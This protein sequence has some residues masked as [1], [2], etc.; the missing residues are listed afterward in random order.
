MRYSYLF[1]VFFCFGLV[2]DEVNVIPRPN[3]LRLKKGHFFQFSG[4]LKVK[5]TKEVQSLSTLLKLDHR[6]VSKSADLNVVL[7][8]KA[9][10][11]KGSYRLRVSRSG[12]Y[13][14]SRNRA[15]LVN[16]IATL[17]Q[18]LLQ[19]RKGTAY[20]VPMLQIR[21]VPSYAYRGLM[22]DSARHFQS[23]KGIKRLLDQMALF[24]L[25]VFHWHLTD[26]EGWRAEVTEFPNL[27]KIGG[28]LDPQELED[29]RNGYYTEK[30]LREVARYANFRGIEVIPEID[31]P[32]HS[33]A[34]VEACPELACPTHKVA[35]PSEWISNQGPERPL[36]G[37]DRS[38]I[39]CVGNDKL[40][41]FLVT[42]YKSVAKSTGA[43]RVHIGGDEVQKG[44]WSKCPKCTGLMKKQGLKDEYDLER[45]FLNQVS[46]RLRQEG[47]EVINWCESPEKGLPNVNATLVWRGKYGS[48]RSHIYDSV[49]QGKKVILARDD[50]A[51]YNYP[52][53]LGTA[54]PRWMPS[55]S[56]E[57]VYKFPLVEE[58]LNAE[59]KSLIIGGQCSLWTEN[60]L[61]K[62]IDEMLFPRVL[63]FSERLWTKSTRQDYASFSSRF[64]RLKPTL[65]DLG[66]SFSKPVL[67]GEVIA[68]KG[69]EVRSNME[70]LLANYAEYAF[71]Q[72]DT[73][74]FVSAKPAQA[75]DFVM[76]L[77]PK[78]VL[79]KEIVVQTGGFF[80]FDEQKGQA[81]YAILEASRDGDTWESLSEL[82]DAYTKVNVKRSYKAIRLRITKSQ[83]RRLVLPEFKIV[84]RK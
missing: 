41:D 39:L 78:A 47:L 21:D 42:I 55:L 30:E 27:T 35:Y 61:E 65:S 59:E 24:K 14:S 48:S 72:D 84:F 52:Q 67:R 33:S 31:V 73:T 75:G 6:R 62:K 15:G 83:E 60:V 12:M 69:V 18:L 8:S 34:L 81:E 74:A 3:L 80:I 54:K 23:V 20:S 25:N 49:K 43:K 5:L 77:F 10:K 46:G 36:T 22:L 32:G 57:K 9:P 38:Y 79:M 53:F 19:S 44:I 45:Y 76:L 71:D 1:F 51:Y 28:F 68:M 82:K 26:N 7:T 4:T 29:E 66:L 16:G 40:M 70:P 17:N 58:G 11:E 64:K 50:Y 63:A 13:L 37:A 56:L 2:A